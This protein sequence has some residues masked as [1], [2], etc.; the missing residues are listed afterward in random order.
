MAT[1]PVVASATPAWVWLPRRAIPLVCTLAVLTV[2]HD[3]DHVRQGRSLPAVLYVVAAGAL[4]SLGM[5]LTVLLRRPRW[6][7]AAA[8]AQGVATVVGVGAVHALPEWSRYAD[9]Y[10]AAGADALS[11]AIVLAMMAAGL[12]L[13][14]VA[15]G[16][17]RRS[18]GAKP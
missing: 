18:A 3:L 1:G 10:P 2:V 16:R 14:V 11:W 12:A 6:A 4:V 5:T 9:S 15:L 7:R 8:G 17:P 13:V